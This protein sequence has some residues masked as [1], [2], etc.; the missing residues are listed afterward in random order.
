MGSQRTAKEG[1]TQ[2]E[3]EGGRQR[4][5]PETKG[6]DTKVLCRRA[7]STAASGAIWGLAREAKPPVSACMCRGTKPRK[8]AAGPQG[9]SLSA[10]QQPRGFLKV[11]R[12]VPC[13][14][15]GPRQGRER[16]GF[17]PG[18][19]S[20]SRSLSSGPGD[21]LQLDWGEAAP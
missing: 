19:L 10:A 9:T 5:V 14:P 13:A 6:E 7:S 1:K 17:M 20:P 12:L 11:P 18:P 3:A 4:E 8:P 15:L 21:G 2:N 16:V